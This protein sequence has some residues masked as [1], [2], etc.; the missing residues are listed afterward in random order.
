MQ[1]AHGSRRNGVRRDAHPRTRHSCFRRTST[2]SKHSSWCNADRKPLGHGAPPLVDPTLRIIR[3]TVAHWRALEELALAVQKAHGSRLRPTAAKLLLQG[4]VGH[5]AWSR[6]AIRRWISPSSRLP[7]TSGST[8]ENQQID[9]AYP[10]NHRLSMMRRRAEMT[11][12]AI[13]HFHHQGFGL[14]VLRLR[15]HRPCGKPPVPRLKLRVPHRR[16]NCARCCGSKIPLR[17]AAARAC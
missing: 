3:P 5:R 15:K 8:A 17:S 2:T 9:K 6:C 4:F 7:G 11:P 1:P 10:R 13:I 14:D 16:R 12:A